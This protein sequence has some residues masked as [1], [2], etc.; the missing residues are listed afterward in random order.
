MGEHVPLFWDAEDV[1]GL[2]G[3][4]QKSGTYTAFVPGFLRDLNYR[5][6]P[7]VEEQVLRATVALSR[8]DNAV[9]AAGRYLNHLLIRSESISSS[10]I[11]GNV[12]S[13]KKLAIADI[14]HASGQVAIDV[15]ANVHA[16]ESAIGELSRPERPFTVEDI[17]D[18]QH[19]IVPVLDYGFRTVQNWIG[20]S[21]WSPLSATFVPPPP[22]YVPGLMADLVDYENDQ[23]GNPIV[24]AAL[25]HA[26]FET[27]HPFIDGNG[28]T[29]RALIHAVLKRSGLIRE[30]LVPVS[31]VFAAHKDSY[32]AGLNGIHSGGTSTDRFVL[33]FAE[34]LQIAASQTVTLAQDVQAV[35][36]LFKTRLFEYRQREGKIPAA[37]RAGSTVLKVLES[38]PQ[39]PAITIQH[40]MTRFDISRN[41][42][43]LALEQL[44]A[45]G[46]LTR[47][48]FKGQR[49]CYVADDYLHLVTMTERST[50]IGGQQTVGQHIELA[51]TL[52]Q[53]VHCRST[54]GPKL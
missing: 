19:Q 40:V 36:K 21:G 8:A 7:A 4:D 16:T 1:Q 45:A 52:P 30:A 38:L 33:D 32:I 28:R 44:A 54:N 5:P 15:I 6:S 29:G 18:L 46:V 10:W 14:T 11:E 49:V 9:T 35:S 48:K 26:Q 37:P 23:F 2:P 53:T 20:G 25:I 27:I 13:A 31:T 41:N 42:A 43:A 50:R 3:R 12:I 51:P 22:E 39:Q 24:R 47:Q 17:K 34:A